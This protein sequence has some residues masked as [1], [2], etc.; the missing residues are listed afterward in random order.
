[1]LPKLYST[2][3]CPKCGNRTYKVIG[4]KLPG[5]GFSYEYVYAEF[6][7]E[8]DVIVKDHDEYILVKCYHC[9]YSWNEAC[10]NGEI[11]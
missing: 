7:Y 8:N 5:D 2:N 1:V 3:Q 9:G 4:E 11:K 10:L 6:H